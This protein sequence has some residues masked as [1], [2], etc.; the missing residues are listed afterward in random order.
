VATI[1]TRREVRRSS[2]RG[3]CP[4]C[5][6]REL[7]TCKC[8]KE[9]RRRIGEARHHLRLGRPSMARSELAN[10]DRL[11]ELLSKDAHHASR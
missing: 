4:R 7:R 8:M 11:M 3:G 10:A 1:S 5:G 6:D 9:I 2:A